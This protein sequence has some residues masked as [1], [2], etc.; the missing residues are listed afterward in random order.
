MKLYI[1]S[2]FLLLWTVGCHQKTTY[3]SETLQSTVAAVP[4]PALADTIEQAV[5]AIE[6]NRGLVR[7]SRTVFV[8]PKTDIEIIRF[9]VGYDPKQLIKLRYQYR[10]P[11][12]LEIVHYYFQRDT[13]FHLHDYR[14]EKQCEGGKKSCAE[15]TKYYFRNG[16]LKSALQRKAES[17]P[18]AVPLIEQGAFRPFTPSDSL[19][20]AKR[21]NIQALEKKFATLPKPTPK[22]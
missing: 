19:V 16:Q 8:D 9:H 18:G 1:L 13:L 7:D 5:A 17:A 15:E 10:S 14:M 20:Q 22:N 11:E 3:Q 4:V 21:D 2:L 6:I 12:R